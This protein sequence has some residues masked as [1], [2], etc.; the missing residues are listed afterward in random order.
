M[1]F[2]SFFS[3][4]GLKLLAAGVLAA[5]MLAAWLY[6]HHLQVENQVLTANNAVQAQQLDDLAAVNKANLAE[7][8]KIRADAAAND[9]ALVAERDDA[10]RRAQDLSTAKK[11]VAHAALSDDKAC[12]VPASIRA[13]LGSLRGVPVDGAGAAPGH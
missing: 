8:A 11:A 10:L 5:V 4:L 3:G 2:A 1:P 12:P 6:V 7:I 9:A 13:A